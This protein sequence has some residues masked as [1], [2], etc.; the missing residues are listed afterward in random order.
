[1]T[2]KEVRAN[3]AHMTGHPPLFANPWSSLSTK[4]YMIDIV[5]NLLKTAWQ[6]GTASCKPV[7]SCSLGN[8]VPVE[9]SQYPRPA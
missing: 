7:F 8:P 9:R 3:V 6:G 5:D 1:M 4:M 2:S